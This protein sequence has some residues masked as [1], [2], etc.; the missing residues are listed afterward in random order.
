[1]EK[2]KIIAAID[3]S[4]H[5]SKV[6]EKAIE[7]AQLMGLEVLLVHCHKKFPTILGEPYREKAI[8]DIVSSAEDTVKPFRKML[9]NSEVGFSE[10]VLEGPAGSVIPEVATIEKCHMI[11]MGSRGLTDLEGLIIGSVTHRVL[12]LASCPVLVIK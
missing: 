11:V 9:Q 10:R 4:F 12:H 6:I 5:S 7:F 1:M 2:G 3:G 8:N